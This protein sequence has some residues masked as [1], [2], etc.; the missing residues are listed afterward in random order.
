MAPFSTERDDG[1]AKGATQDEICWCVARGEQQT[2]VGAV[3]LD[4]GG[5]GPGHAD[6]GF[7][8]QGGVGWHREEGEGG[9]GVGDGYGGVGWG[10]RRREGGHFGFGL[11]F[12]S[13]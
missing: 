3:E 12:V 10:D 9:A 5:G 6:E 8:G 1:A 11:C 4:W 2:T 13:G 7:G